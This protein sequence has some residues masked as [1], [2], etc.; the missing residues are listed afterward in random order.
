VS[1]HSPRLVASAG[2]VDVWFA[3]GAALAAAAA[4]LPTMYPDVGGGGD[5]MKFQYLGQVLGTAHPP[6]YPLYVFVSHA[7]S[8]VPIGTPALRMNLLSAVLGAAGVALVYGLSRAVGAGRIVALGAA[9]GLAFGRD[10]WSKSLVAEVYSLNAALVAGIGLC[11]VTWGRGG[12]RAWAFYGA[13]T[14]FAL[15]TGNHLTVVFIVPA[16]VGYAIWTDWRESLS[17]RRV[18]ASAAILAA[19]LAQY[20]FIIVRTRQDSP[21][22]EAR[23]TNLGELLTVVRADHYSGLIGA[24]SASDLWTTRLWEVTRAAAGGLGWTGVVLGAIGLVPLAR[25]RPRE[26]ALFLGGATGVFLLTINVDADVAGF[27][28]P[29]YVLLAPVVAWGLQTLVRVP[30]ALE[31]PWLAP[32]AAAVTA[33]VPLAANYAPNDHSR[34]SYERR[35]GDALFETLPD[36]SAIVQEGYTGTS[37]VRYFLA[38]EDAAQGREIHLVPPDPELLRRMDDDG[39]AIFAFEL[40]REALSLSAFSFVPEQLLDVPL[41]SQIDQ[42][43]RNWRVV[44]AAPRGALRD[45]PEDRLDVLHAAGRPAV[46]SWRRL[47]GVILTSSDGA[48]ESDFAG[49]VALAWSGDA[50]SFGYFAGHIAAEAGLGRAAIHVDDQSYTTD[51]TGVLAAIFAGGRL[52]DVERADPTRQLRTPFPDET[53]GRLT[54]APECIAF[55]NRGWVNIRP[56]FGR[57]GTRLRMDNYRPFD[58]RLELYVVA[59]SPPA[60]GTVFDGPRSPSV[61]VDRVDTDLVP[62][63]AAAALGPIPPEAFVYRFAA[64]VNDDGQSATIDWAPGVPVLAA[65]GRAMVDLSNPQRATACEAPAVSGA[66]ALR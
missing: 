38:A 61:A 40:G 50:T 22:T 66:S 19:G 34:H 65:V 32:A 46:D 44:M 13:V 58:G 21:Y 35:L 15:A 43:G 31:R 47:A 16:L 18:L 63:A 8:Y 25:R 6:G 27:L 52:V 53:L 41:W 59:G 23:A 54:D 3:L 42:L 64:D 49:D 62:Q 36:R 28:L 17:S 20:L 57:A 1:V 48:V 39:Y 5:A 51:G 56:A 55:G 30:G 60:T 4:Y 37:L 29:V 10:Y 33:F 26:A 11:L 24:F 14:L 45:W 7:F 12:R 2:W 9:L